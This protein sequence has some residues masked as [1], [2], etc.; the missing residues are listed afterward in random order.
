MQHNTE[1]VHNFFETLSSEGVRAAL[2]RH[3]IT[4][5]VWWSAGAGEVEDRIADFMDAFG[6]EVSGAVDLAVL[7]TTAEG[8]RVAVEV[9]LYAELSGNRVYRN[10]FH[11]LFELRNGAITRISEYHDTRH[12]YD[13]IGATL[14]KVGFIND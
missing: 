7:G 8:N 3:A 1:I 14:R 10:Q 5:V 12:A 4:E 13:T 9:T 11:F 6:A 2:D